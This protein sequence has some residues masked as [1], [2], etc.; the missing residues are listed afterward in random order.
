MKITSQNKSSCPVCS[1]TTALSL[2]KSN[3]YEILRC[4]TCACDFVWPMPDKQTLKAYYDGES[5]FHSDSTGSYA[6]Y[7]STTDAAI[8]LFR[9]FILTIPNVAGKKIL[10]IGCAFGTH[11]ALASEQ[12]WE[13]WGVELSDHARDIALSRHGEKIHVVEG[14]DNLPKMEFDLII[15]LDV[16]EHLPEPY[17]LFLELFL[18]GAIGKKTQLVITTP[19]ARSVDAL[20]DP[21]AWIY[22]HPPSHLVYFSANSLK[23]FLTNLEAVDIS[24]QGI[25][26]IGYQDSCDYL[27]ENEASNRDVKNYAGLMGV[28]QGFD[29]SLHKLLALFKDKS[30]SIKNPELKSLYQ[31][32]FAIQ[33]QVIQKHA[34]EEQSLKV[35]I[36]R[37]AQEVIRLNEVILAKD[38][39]ITQKNQEIGFLNQALDEKKL[40][41][42]KRVQEI[43]S[44]QQSK[45]YRLGNALKM[46][47]MTV[48]NFARIVYLSAGLIVPLTWRVKVAPIVSKLR[49]QYLN[50]RQILLD[51]MVENG[52]YLAKPSTTVWQRVVKLFQFWT[53]PSD[54]PYKGE[55]LH[56]GVNAKILL[57]VHDFSR[58]GAP[59]AVLYL[60]R[61][62]FSLY[63]VRPVVISPKEGPI[64]EEFEQE[65][66]PTIVDPLLF[67]C[68]DYSSEARDFVVT[69]ERVIVTSL[70]SFSFIHYFKDIS[71]H[72][73]WWIHETDVGFNAVANMTSDLPLLFAACE[74][75][76]LGSPLCFPLA[77]QYTSQEKLHLLLYG[78]S[79]TAIPNR[80]H[81]SG[82][83]VFS[84]VGSVEPRKG[85]D[86]FLD[87]IGRLPEELRAKAVFRIIG[88]PLPYH[89]SII[90]YKEVSAKAALIPE[91]ECIENMPSDKLLEFYAETNVLVSASR[92]DPMPIVITQ[93]LMF[94]K[95]CLCS[96]S[97]GHAQL[98]ENRKNGLIFTNES[99]EELSGKMVFLLQNPTELAALGVAGREV[100]EQYFLMSSFVGN[101]GNLIADYR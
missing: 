65:G 37:Q 73:T 23:L 87:A 88:S 66:F 94:S 98:L 84:L 83:I 69:F 93:G 74:S 12:G 61:A 50:A 75:I 92:D 81:K 17:D 57:V 15:M 51:K 79:D 34:F 96:S 4:G 68:Q 70:G 72:L 5:Y 52:D 89:E 1:G 25:Y 33:K 20:V 19:N 95:A 86:V 49:Q 8:P 64:R 58:T 60:A 55:V 29:I 30:I 42:E 76:W 44:M 85:Q 78:C 90:F 7:D 13:A 38:S 14:I 45:W 59:Y 97:I 40:E 22:R 39:I 18:H 80:P 91:V 101:V 6:D 43:L 16:L 31:E 2:C 36:A 26:P 71:K 82:K 32:I 56:L 53:A 41:L 3:G 77:L 21:S 63:G 11:L 99:A 24:I 46:R 54:T 47:P 67:D 28:V 27:D 10:D 62:L 9:D 48:H 100:Y 35:E